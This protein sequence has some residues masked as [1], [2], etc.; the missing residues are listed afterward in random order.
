MKNI[1]YQ[2]ITDLGIEEISI[3]IPESYKDCATLIKSDYYRRR[4]VIIPIWKI[5]FKSI[6]YPCRAAAFWLR[7]SLYKKGVFYIIAKIMY[8][9]YRLHHAIDI[10]AKHI[11]YGLYIGHPHLQISDNAV[12]G[13]NVNLSQFTSIGT[14]T[15]HGAIIGNNVYIGPSVCIVE[16]VNIGSNTTIGAGTIV[17]KDLPPNSTY[18]GNPARRVGENKHPEFIRNPWPI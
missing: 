9:Y 5:F 17:V 3:P 8:R 14:N 16:G 15:K 4:G 2:L 13:N 1:N 10:R 18:V 6:P 7:L 12:I 11:G